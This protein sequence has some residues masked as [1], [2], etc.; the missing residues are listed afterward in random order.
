MLL[1]KSSPWCLSLVLLT[2]Y[3]SDAFVLPQQN[4][5]LFDTSSRADEVTHN[6]LSRADYP[7][8]QMR[9]RDRFRRK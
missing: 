9:K 1:S 3:S 4:R 6:M 2:L 8:F 7:G 5:N